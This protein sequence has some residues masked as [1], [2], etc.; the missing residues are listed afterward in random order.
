M[1]NWQ[2][3]DPVAWV[4]AWCEA[5]PVKIRICQYL[6]SRKMV[7]HYRAVWWTK[8]W[9]NFWNKVRECNVRFII[10]LVNPQSMIL[11]SGMDSVRTLLWTSNI[12]SY[13][14]TKMT[15]QTLR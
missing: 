12:Y 11:I 9:L 5:N 15:A 6:V 7:K 4:D 3:Q 8:S 1:R 2:G 13:I 10:D 14:L